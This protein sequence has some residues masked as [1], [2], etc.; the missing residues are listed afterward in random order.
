MNLLA[1][2]IA[3]FFTPGIIAL[4]FHRPILR[5]LDRFF[6]KKLEVEKFNAT[7]PYAQGLFR[8]TH[9]ECNRSE[10]K[11]IGELPSDLNGIYLRNGP[12]QRF[13]PTGRMHMFDGEGM[14]HQIQIQDGKAYYSNTY[15]KTPKYQFNASAQKDSFTHVGDLAGGGA[16]GMAKI[17]CEL[18]KK[19]LGMLPK[20]SRLESGSNSTALLFHH[21]KLF[22]LQEISYP[23]NLDL[24]FSSTGA[25]K[26]SGEGAFE[27]FNKRLK[28]PFSAHVKIDPQTNDVVFF[29]NS[30]DTKEIYYAELDPKGELKTFKAIKK[31]NPCIGFLHDSFITEHFAICPDMSIRFDVQQMNKDPQSPW[32]FDPNTTL[33]FGVLQRKKIGESPIQETVQWFDTEKAGFIWHTINAW[34][35]RNSSGELELVLFAPVFDQYPSNIP[36]HLPEEPHATV[37]MWRLN[38]EKGTISEHRTLLD[39]FFERPSINDRYLG[40]RHRFTYLLDKTD[41]RGVLGCGVQKYHLQEERIVKSFSYGDFF[42]GEP[43]FVAKKDAVEEDDGYIVELLMSESESQ[44]IVL[45]A[46]SLE[47]CTRLILPQRVPFGVHS[48]WIPQNDIQPTVNPLSS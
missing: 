38:L 33:K 15:I 1:L 27:D 23:F 41:P 37:Q 46:N 43:L 45:D 8:P 47:E 13:E 28:A 6:Y 19:R 20:L 29:S 14:I 25:L 22:A 34:E 10:I 30:V 42:G 48:L 32:F 24:D 16:M 26:L 31:D 3:L 2:S 35:E 7:N 11:I 9:N 36:I 12:N 4:V 40:K 5:T 17:V 18:L 21:G 44:L 39:R